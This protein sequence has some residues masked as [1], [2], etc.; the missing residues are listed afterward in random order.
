MIKYVIA[1]SGSK[2]N[3]T[4]IYSETTIIQIDMGLPLRAINN[5]ISLNNHYSNRYGAPLT[6]NK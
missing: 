2:G 4:F 3:A 5:A 6:G 1:G